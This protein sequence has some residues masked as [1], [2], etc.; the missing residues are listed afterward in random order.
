[1]KAPTGRNAS[2]I[3]IENAISK[4]ERLNSLPMAVRQ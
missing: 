1:M 3:V 4:S 2:V